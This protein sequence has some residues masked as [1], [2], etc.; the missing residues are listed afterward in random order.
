MDEI[1]EPKLFMLPKP[2][3][4]WWASWGDKCEPFGDYTLEYFPPNVDVAAYWYVSGFY[5][6]MGHIVYRVKGKWQHASCSHCSC[7]G[8]TENMSDDGS[9]DT[10]DELLSHC[11]EGLIEE[12]LPALVALLKEN[13]FN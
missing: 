5:E 9:E 1:E 7:Y 13:G 3:E 6:G 10:L 8:P 4:G 11:S 2:P 12:G